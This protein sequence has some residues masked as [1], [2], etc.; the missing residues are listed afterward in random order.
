MMSMR[1]F[2]WRC[3]TP[4]VYLAHRAGWCSYEWVNVCHG[5]WRRDR[6]DPLWHHERYGDPIETLPDTTILCGIR[7]DVQA[8]E[9]LVVF[10]CDWSARTVVFERD[11]HDP[12]A[13]LWYAEINGRVPASHVDMAYR[14]I[15]AVFGGS[16]VRKRST[17]AAPQVRRLSLPNN[18]RPA[19]GVGQ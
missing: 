12:F 11:D 13:D 4:A 16:H 6:F 3:A 14:W 7:Y 9:G 1:R 18:S 15:R 2:L 17:V 8:H 19:G 10:R 5:A